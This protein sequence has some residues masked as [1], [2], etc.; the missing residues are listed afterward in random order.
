MKIYS[1]ESLWQVHH[2]KNLL[3]AENIGCFIRN[4]NMT[5]LAGEVPATECWPE[6]WLKDERQLTIAESIIKQLNQTPDPQLTKWRCENCQEVNEG[7]FA[8]CWQCGNMAPK[9]ITT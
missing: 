6:L 7:Q 3:E 4:D 1:H 8:I 5:S 2:L 9:T